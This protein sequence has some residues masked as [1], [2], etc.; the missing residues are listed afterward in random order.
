MSSEI[1]RFLRQAQLD[2]R[3]TRPRY[4]HKPRLLTAKEKRADVRARIEN[5]LVLLF[6]DPLPYERL[7]VVCGRSYEY[8]RKA[9]RIR[10]SG[11]PAI[12]REAIKLLT[13]G[14]RAH[15]MGLR[16]HLSDVDAQIVR[17]TDALDEAGLYDSK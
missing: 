16:D 2:P 4:G 5:L 13:Q 6:N 8:W 10:P 11:E 7:T 9:L 15:V 1:D 12:T 17:V 14:L 3:H